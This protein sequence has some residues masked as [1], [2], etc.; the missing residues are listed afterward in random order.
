MKNSTEDKTYQISHMPMDI[1]ESNIEKYNSKCYYY[2]RGYC[3]KKN[4][5]LFFHP[6]MDCIENCP[7]KTICNKRHRKHCK[8][9]NN[10][11][12]NRQQICEFKHDK[13]N[14]THIYKKTETDIV[15]KLTDSIED[16]YKD[17]IKELESE[18]EDLKLILNKEKIETIQ[19]EMIRKRAHEESMAN[20][21]KIKDMKVQHKK[22]ILIK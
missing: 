10:C 22:K 7:G 11:Y 1:E 14:S 19:I 6:T 17:K 8:Y 2:N 12:H 3:K 21:D 18:I 9:G 4:N 20:L 13:I 16:T 15:N 5:C